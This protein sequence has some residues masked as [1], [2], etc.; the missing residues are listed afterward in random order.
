MVQFEK[1]GKVAKI[2]LNRPEK[3]NSLI[4]EMALEIQTKLD[5]CS[6]DTEIRCILITGSGKAFCAGHLP[7]PVNRS[8]WKR[9]TCK[10]GNPVS[11]YL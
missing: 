10:P 4:R 8:L 3:Y 5:E 11:F 2:I 1:I 9:F 7:F 6:S